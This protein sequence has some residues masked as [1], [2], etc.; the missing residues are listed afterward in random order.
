[1]L[2]YDG[3]GAFL[4][5]LPGVLK[6]SDFGRYVEL[7]MADGADAQTILTAA[8]A[9]RPKSRYAAP[10]SARVVIAASTLLPDRLLD[11]GTR[12]LMALLR[13]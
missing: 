1:V 9:R 11:A 13:R 6:V 8:M 4:A 7:K 12:G 10:F 3:D 5:A 2:A